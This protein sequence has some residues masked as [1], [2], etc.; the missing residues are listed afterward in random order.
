[1]TI[2]ADNLTYRKCSISGEAPAEHKRASRSRSDTPEMTLKRQQT[3]QTVTPTD[4]P[5]SNRTPVAMLQ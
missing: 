5:P 2:T 4:A 1:V 3:G